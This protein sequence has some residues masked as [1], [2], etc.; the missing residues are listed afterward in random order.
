MCN[1]T[2]L[3]RENT[4]HLLELRIRKLHKELPPEEFAALGEEIAALGE[5]IA[6]HCDEVAASACLA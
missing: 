6:S 2:V 5:G 3:N 4:F 1:V